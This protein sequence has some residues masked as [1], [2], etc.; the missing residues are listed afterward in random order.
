[1]NGDLHV[2]A[3]DALVILG[4][5]ATAVAYVRSIARFRR[6]ERIAFVAGALALA[7]ALLSPLDS[8]A[9]TR[10]WIHMLQHELLVLVAAPLLVLGDPLRAWSRATPRAMLRPLR[11]ATP[12]LATTLHAV[13]LW[14]WHAPRLFEASVT[15]EGVH[16]AQHLSFFGTA[17]L[18]WWTVL[19][20]AP[21]GIAVLCVAA[22]MIHM[23]VLGALLTFAPAPIY[24]HYALQDQQLGGLVMWV[25]AGFV[26]LFAGLWTFDR[27]L[28][29]QS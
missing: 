24:A 26:V 29:L 1:M 22:T 2:H 12:V 11:H 18:F 19:R 6:V 8:L 23:G 9:A 4:L 15:N 13:A 20:R 16:A 3:S 14:V 21:C 27:W 25:P 17:L 5:A 7:V 10:F 28:R